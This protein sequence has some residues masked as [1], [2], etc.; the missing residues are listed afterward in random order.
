MMYMPQKQLELPLLTNEGSIVLVRLFL[1]PF[2]PSYSAN[3][4]LCTVNKEKLM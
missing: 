3:M 1:F 4:I 2:Y